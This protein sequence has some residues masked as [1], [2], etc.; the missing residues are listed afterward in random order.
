MIVAIGSENPVKFM[1]V[2]EGFTTVWPER[3]I[4][5]EKVK[6]KSGVSDQ[7]M[8]DE[9]SF[10]GARNRAKQALK[11]L[12]ADFG[13]GLEG[14]IQQI[15]EKWFD[16]GCIVILDKHGKEGS[17]SSLRIET[18]PVMIELIKQGL[19]LG[20]VNDLLFKRE[21]SKHAEGHFGLMTN[22]LI[23]RQHGYIDAV[24]GA[25]SIFL[26]PELFE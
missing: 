4:L 7:P 16:S 12:N 22:G 17:S 19:E 26:H 8:S 18:P 25:L 14:G 10:K 24:I 11:M 6:V 1:A 13:I 5:F 3:N 21:N 2:K 20:E 15:G 23:S 9:E